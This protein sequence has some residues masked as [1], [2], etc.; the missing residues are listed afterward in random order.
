MVLF[1]ETKALQFFR[2]PVLK[3]KIQADILTKKYINSICILENK[4][5]HLKALSKKYFGVKNI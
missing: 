1:P 3:L 4:Y 5:L 2:D